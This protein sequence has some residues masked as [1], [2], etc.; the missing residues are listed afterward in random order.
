MNTVDIILIILLAA[1]VFFA[2]RKVIKDKK[3]GKSC[4]CGC[5]GC[6]KDCPA[7]REDGAKR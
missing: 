2:A 6:N 5:S 3:S 7:R 4:S 1:A